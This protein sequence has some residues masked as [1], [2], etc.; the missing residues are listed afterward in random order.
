MVGVEPAM[1]VAA[2]MRQGL[3]DIVRNRDPL[4]G[5]WLLVMTG[6]LHKSDIAV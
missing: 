5:Q 4:T 3:V 1:A 2:K 6:V